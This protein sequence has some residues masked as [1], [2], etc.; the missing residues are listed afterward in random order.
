MNINKNCELILNNIYLYDIVSCHFTILDRLGY[1]IN[2]ISKNG[3]NDKIS[4]NIQIGYLM[5]KNPHLT[6]LLR[7][8][9]ESLVNEFILR[10]NIKEDEIICCQYDGLLINRPAIEYNQYV[11]F[12]LREI[13]SI[14]I[15]SNN[16]YNYIAINNQDKIIIKGITNRYEHM[17]YYYLKLL[18]INY[19][20]K[21]SIFRSLQ[22]IKNEMYN[23]NNPEL[24]CIPIKDKYEIFLKRYGKIKIS[25][26]IINMLDVD[27]IDKNFYFE[28]YLKPFFNS[29]VITY[30]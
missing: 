18:K 8:Y 1:D 30:I 29:I 25:E 15:L 14:M 16:R 26:T 17:D 24:F 2:S 23:C 11:N 6:S 4:R 9:T 19:S 28:T 22:K 13:Y 5:K 20:N 12:C 3:K 27:E 7:L 10:N 21:Q